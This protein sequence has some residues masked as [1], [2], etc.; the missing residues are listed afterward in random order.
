MNITQPSI[1][2]TLTFDNFDLDKRDDFEIR[3]FDLDI[4]HF[5]YARNFDWNQF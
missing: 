3:L 4:H 1:Y 2:V 5:R